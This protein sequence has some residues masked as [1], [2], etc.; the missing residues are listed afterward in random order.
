ML[1]DY[2]IDENFLS[3]EEL[4][5][6]IPRIEALPYALSISIGAADNGVEGIV[7]DK[8][9]DRLIVVSEAHILDDPDAVAHPLYPIAMELIEKFCSKHQIELLEL[10]R[11]RI[12][13]TFN[14]Q[15]IRPLIPHVDLRNR[16]KHYILL[17]FF[18]DSDAATIMYKLKVDGE[19]HNEDELEIY[20][21]FEAYRG[22]AVLFD[23]DFFHAWEHPKDYEYRLS[24]IAN[25]S[26]RLPLELS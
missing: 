15:D 19:K 22:S 21:R 5:D 12:N 3:D 2:M 18:N 7:G 1:P 16:V 26:V 4:T 6:I 20:K 10:Y 14:S 8:F 11:T 13:V 9:L 25:I 24:M 17:I 23:G